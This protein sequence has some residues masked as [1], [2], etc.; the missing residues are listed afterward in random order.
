MMILELIAITLFFLAPFVAM[1][2]MAWLEKNTFVEYMRLFHLTWLFHVRDF[3]EASENDTELR[4]T[5]FLVE[6]W[7]NWL[8]RLL[9]CPICLSPW[10]SVLPN[11]GLYAIMFGSY[12]ILSVLVFTV[13]GTML[14]SYAGL[15]LYFKLVKMMK[16]E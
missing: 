10:I 1:A 7:P 11:L 6:Y 16:H 15:Y 3:I 13:F 8:T 5:K 4:Y 12:G 14:T 2:L 9:S